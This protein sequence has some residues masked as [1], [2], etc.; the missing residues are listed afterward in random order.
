MRK[1]TICFTYIILCTT[2]NAQTLQGKKVLWLG[3]SI[4]A[5]CTYPQNACANLGMTCQNNAMG[6]SFLAELPFTIPQEH[7]GYSLS[8]STSE[9]DSAYSHLV[10]TGIISQHRLNVWKFTSYDNRVTPFLKD[11]DIVIIDHGYND[12]FTTKY[13]SSLNENEINWDSEDKRTFIGAF[14]FIYRKI[15]EINPNILIA[16]GGY[17]QNT[18]TFS[19]TI[20]GYHTSKVLTMIANHYKIPLLDTWNYVGIKDGHIP[21]SSTYFQELNEKYKTT[22]YNQFPDSEGNITYFQKFCPDGVH[23]FSDPTGESDKLLDE[24]FTQLLQ[25]KLL[26]YYSNIAETLN[27]TNSYPI[28]ILTINGIKKTDLTRGLNIIRMSDGTTKKVIVK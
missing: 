26:P 21:N 3:T 11:V 8:M 17:F 9:K 7:S 13:E 12:H 4:P 18:C 22:Y 15:K 5:E 6:A 10:T 1:L 14:N 23:P 24:I 2:I 20:S 28:D 27:T 25:E 19:Y 16:I